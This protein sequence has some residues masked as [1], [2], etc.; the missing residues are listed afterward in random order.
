MQPDSAIELKHAFTT[1]LSGAGAT[2]LD[3]FFCE[4]ATIEPHNNTPSAE[5]TTPRKQPVVSFI[6]FSSAVHFQHLD[7][8]QDAGAYSPRKTVGTKIREN[9]VIQRRKWGKSK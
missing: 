7:P 2:Q 5:T 9:S 4:F 3:R 6:L 8:R 1:G